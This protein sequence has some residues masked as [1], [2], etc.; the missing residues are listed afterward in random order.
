MVREAV[1][2]ALLAAVVAG[3][4]V[5]YN[6]FRASS[7]RA[8]MDENLELKQQLDDLQE[9]LDDLRRE[10]QRLTTAL[11]LLKVDHR[12]AQID[13]LSQEGSAATGDLATHFTFVELN[14]DGK[15]IEEPRQFRVAGDVLYIESWVV[16]FGDEYVEQGDPLRST[17]LCLFRRLFGEAQRPV[18][19][20]ELDRD[21]LRPAAYR[22]GGAPSDLEEEI[23]QR[24]WD[25]ANDPDA[26]AELGVR[27]VHGEAP[28]QKMVPGKRYKVLLRAS[29][30]L[31]IAAEDLPPEAKPVTTA[32]TL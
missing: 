24:F 25:L 13:V 19:G 20:F 22:N 6:E 31:S 21:G 16:K 12:V 15:P 14:G 2:L 17:S 32:E 3:I 28:F 7:A 5:F 18:D 9:Q 10:N 23:W 11:R 26:A 4:V 30:G 1:A 29:G 8:L 27:V